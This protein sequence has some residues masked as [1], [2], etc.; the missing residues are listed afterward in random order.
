MDNG[1]M[2]T[3]LLL[4]ALLLTFPIQAATTVTIA[5]GQFDRADTVVVFAFPKSLDPK[6]NYGLVKDG[7]TLPIQLIP[8]NRALHIRGLRDEAGNELP[9]QLLPEYRAIFILKSLK[10]GESLTFSLESIPWATRPPLPTDMSAKEDDTQVKLSVG[11]QTLLRYNG[12]PTGLPEGYDPSFQRGGY[13]FPI[14]T[15]S[16]RVVCDDYP[17]MHKHHHGIWF[18]WTATQFEG[19]KPD[20]WNMGQKKGRVEFVQLGSTFSG[21]VAAGLRTSHR[22]VDSSAPN[23]SKVALNETWN[24]TAYGVGVKAADTKDAKPYFVFDIDCTQVCAGE[25][26][27]KLPKYHY[28]GMGFR[29]HRDWNAKTPD[30]Y[31]VLTS[32]G[33]GRKNSNESTARW[34]HM[35]GQVEG[36]PVGLAMLD[37]P[38]NFRSPQPLRVHPTEPFFC[39]APQVAGDFEITPGKPYVSKYRVVVSDG[40]PDAKLLDRMWNDYA[41][42][43]EVSIR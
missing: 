41:H 37:H 11:E 30:A 42:P 34:M 12:K 43:V 24:V 13:L 40:A 36:Q 38:S 10:A 18:A 15:P 5:A 27:L 28:G 31:T 9:P 39:Y 29:G 26:P 14:L 19:R 25:A 20:F 4:L 17:P 32:E 16:G 2:R 3:T 8:E 21:P 33:K 7:Q 22:Y 6:A 35:G 1:P 23:I